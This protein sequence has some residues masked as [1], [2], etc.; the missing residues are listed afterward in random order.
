MLK[1]LS[2]KRMINS[3]QHVT[4]ENN[5]CK[6]MKKIISIIVLLIST[7]SFSQYYKTY[8]WETS[9]KLHELTIDELNEF[10]ESK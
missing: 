1:S 8:D 2:P 4:F 7:Q 10:L 9:P 3:E 5:K 6:H